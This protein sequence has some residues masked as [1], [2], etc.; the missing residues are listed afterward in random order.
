V[1]KGSPYAILRYICHKG[2][3]YG[4]QTNSGMIKHDSSKPEA[5]HETVTVDSGG[6]GSESKKWKFVAED[7]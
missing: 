1:G 4:R 2:A 3:F 6:L 5:Q 7:T